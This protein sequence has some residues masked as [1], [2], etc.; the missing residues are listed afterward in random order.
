MEDLLA[1]LQAADGHH[2][3]EDFAKLVATEVTPTRVTDRGHDLVELPPN[4]QG[5]TALLLAK[6]LERFGISF[7]NRG[8][9]FNLRAG[10]GWFGFVRWC[11]MPLASQILLKRMGWQ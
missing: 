10:Q 1:T 3:A 4:G 7:Q 6:I 11:S 2:T 9:G 5:A 8:V